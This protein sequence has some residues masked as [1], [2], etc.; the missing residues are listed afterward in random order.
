MKT[1]EK[2]RNEMIETG[3]LALFEI[4][5]KDRRTGKRDYIIF[6]ITVSEDVIEASH[7]SLNVAQSKS[8]KI[9]FESVDIDDDFSLDYHLAA[10]YDECIGAIIESEYYELI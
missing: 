7:V 4:E 1:S 10:L 8:D 9:A 3:L 6:N 5:V 2:L